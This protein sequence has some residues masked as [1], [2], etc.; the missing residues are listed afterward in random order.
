MGLRGRLSRL[1][2]GAREHLESF[3]LLDGSTYYYDRLETCKELFLHA[4][5]VQLGDADKWPEPPEVYRK[6][7][8]ARD[9]AAVLE[10]FMPED[11]QRAFVNLA[12]LCDTD[13]LVRERRLV[14]LSHAGRHPPNRRQEGAPYGWTSL[15]GFRSSGAS[16]RGAD[17]GTRRLEAVGARETLTAPSF[18][19]LPQELPVGELPGEGEPSVLLIDRNPSVTLCRHIKV[20][21]EVSR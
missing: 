15:S 4:Y 13:V 10:Q 2:R 12:E 3:E 14:P 5:D 11:P 8:Q 21:Q 7:C 18:V 6:M 17:S 19:P 16:R 9:V 20:T 1:E